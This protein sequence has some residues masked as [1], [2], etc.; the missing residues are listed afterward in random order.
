MVQEPSVFPVSLFLRI[1]QI[2]GKN[3]AHDLEFLNIL[4]INNHLYFK[5]ENRF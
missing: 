2:I 5:E 3:S 1:Y 4:C